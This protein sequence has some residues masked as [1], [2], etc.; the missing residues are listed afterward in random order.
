MLVLLWDMDPQGIDLHRDRELLFERVMARGTW[1]AMC[2]LRKRFARE[3]LAA[4]VKTRGARVLSPRDLAYWALVCD[5]E[6]PSESGG[7]RPRWAG[8]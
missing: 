3:D 2:W 1:D 7:G 8:P 5:V 4:F 6:V